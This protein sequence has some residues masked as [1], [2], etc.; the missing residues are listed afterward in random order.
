MWLKFS[1]AIMAVGFILQV[2]HGVH[3]TQEDLKLPKCYEISIEA[4]R[5]LLSIPYDIEVHRDNVAMVETEW[6]H[7]FEQEYEE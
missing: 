4:K 3:E 1:L 6:C 7:C 5:A 2:S